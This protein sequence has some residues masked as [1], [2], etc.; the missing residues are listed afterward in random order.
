MTDFFTTPPWTSYIYLEFI[1]A[2]RKRN[3]KTSLRIY[4]NPRH[5][6]IHRI[7]TRRAKF[8]I[9]LILRDEEVNFIGVHRC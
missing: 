8:A 3:S 7:L 5:P 9:S 4:E 6:K 2:I 1:I